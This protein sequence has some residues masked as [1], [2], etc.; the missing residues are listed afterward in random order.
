MYLM[1]GYFLPNFCYAMGFLHMSLYNIHRSYFPGNQEPHG[2]L[3]KNISVKQL[4]M[5]TRSPE[6]GI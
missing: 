6:L 3:A 5:E 4:L 1:M 2:S